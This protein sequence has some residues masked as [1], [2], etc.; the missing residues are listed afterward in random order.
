MVIERKEPSG[1]CGSKAD[2]P[3]MKIVL[4]LCTHRSIDTRTVILS[5]KRDE[6]KKIKG[7]KLYYLSVLYLFSIIYFMLFCILDLGPQPHCSGVAC[8]SA[9]S[10]DSWQG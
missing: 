9:P 7:K 1:P 3:V 2:I 5:T 8:S 10:N 4:E 6:E